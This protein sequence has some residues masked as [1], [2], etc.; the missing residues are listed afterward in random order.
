MLSWKNGHD[1]HEAL[2]VAVH[3]LWMNNVRSTTARQTA[4]AIDAE[5]WD[6]ALRQPDGYYRIT[7]CFNDLIIRFTEN[8][9]ALSNSARH[10]ER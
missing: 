2:D 8:F 5:G 10:A 1:V 7:G 4:K 9:R 6:M 3:L